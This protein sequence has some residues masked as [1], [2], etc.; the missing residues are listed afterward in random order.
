[1]KLQSMLVVLILA[2]TISILA[3]SNSYQSEKLKKIWVT[4]G[5]SVPESV[6]PVYEK[7]I[8][9]VSNIGTNNPNEKENNGFISILGT[10]G[11][12]KNL[13]WC[14]NL[15]SPKGMATYDGFL[16]VTEVNKVS[17][18]D[19]KTGAKVSSVPVKGAIFLNDI[20]VDTQG[21]LYVTDSRTGTIHKIKNDSVN[22]LIK[23]DNF[24]NPNG[25]I[26]ANDK[27]VAGTG[28]NVI[29]VNSGTTEVN[30]CLS[31]TGAV[32]G[33][34]MIE[35]GVFLFSNWPGKIYLMKKGGGKELLL[36]TSSLETSQT[37]DFGY[38]SDTKRIYVPTF[39]GNS[40]VCYELND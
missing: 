40:I 27:V 11:S 28:T 8:L 12:I 19:I 24:P 31:N 10:D 3:Q 9:Y 14:S 34:V 18:I 26:T 1:M 4:E 20:A 25:I 6:L 16:Y 35:P 39:F 33:L 2:N 7:G 17:K 38:I 36:D 15:N 29:S 5:L 13:K 37:A 21:T 32:D 22:V 30:E 23:S